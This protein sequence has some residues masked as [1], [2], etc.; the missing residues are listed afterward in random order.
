[1]NI[2]KIYSYKK[3]T[4]LTRN[5][6]KDFVLHGTSTP[7]RKENSRQYQTNSERT[8]STTNLSQSAILTGLRNGTLS[9]S[10]GKY[11]TY[12]TQQ[13]NDSVSSILKKSSL[14]PGRRRQTGELSLDLQSLNSSLNKSLNKSVSFTEHQ[15]HARQ[16]AEADSDEESLTAFENELQ[17]LIDSDL[18]ENDEYEKKKYQTS[19]IP[20]S[21]WYIDPVHLKDDMEFPVFESLGVS[22]KSVSPHSRTAGMLGTELAQHRINSGIVQDSSTRRYF[23]PTSQSTLRSTVSRPPSENGRSRNYLS[24]CAQLVTKATSDY[25]YLVASQRFVDGEEIVSPYRYELAKLRM[26]RLRLEED[27]ILESKRQDELE[28]IRGPQ[29]KWYELKTPQFCYEAHKNNGLLKSQDEWQNLLDYRQSL[30]KSSKL[31]QG[32]LHQ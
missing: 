17:R 32:S 30:I 22:M 4:M 6:D 29:P 2:L 31:F 9:R 1:M 24:K 10:S 14:K 5:P 26:E 19:N 20:K 21:Q 25:N 13:L 12:D 27:R 11:S 16:K 3:N 28:R 23:L 18:Q 7:L 15:S 8:L